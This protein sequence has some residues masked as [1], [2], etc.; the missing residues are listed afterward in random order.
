MAV[1]KFGGHLRAACEPAKRDLLDW[2]SQSLLEAF[3]AMRMEGP[4]KRSDSDIEWGEL[5]EEVYRWGAENP[6][7][8][9]KFASD[10]LGGAK[11]A[12]VGLAGYAL[13]GS[14]KGSNQPC[15]ATWVPKYKFHPS[16]LCSWSFDLVDGGRMPLSEQELKAVELATREMHLRYLQRYNREGAP[17]VIASI[18][19][20]DL[21][22]PTLGGFEVAESDFSRTNWSLAARSLLSAYESEILNEEARGAAREPGKR[23]R[24]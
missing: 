5:A 18:A 15:E 1:E 8:A 6:V 2:R 7:P 23:A 12:G 9:K 10:Y 3:E 20:S 17:H 11:G 19:A 16:N 22:R 14:L 24:L 13:L 4:R 21:L